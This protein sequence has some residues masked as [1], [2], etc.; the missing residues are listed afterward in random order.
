MLTSA[1]L[2]CRI[3]IPG[4]GQAVRTKG[5]CMLP[6]AR[7]SRRLHRRTAWLHT[8]IS[9]GWGYVRVM[10]RVR[11]GQSLVPACAPY[12]CTAVVGSG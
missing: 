3:V 5:P 6:T 8:A 9:V 10:I 11:S 7:R 1:G 2:D 12:R 4:G